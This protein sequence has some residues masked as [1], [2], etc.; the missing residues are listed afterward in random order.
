[1][2]SRSSEGMADSDDY[3][4]SLEDVIDYENITDTCMME[5]NSPDESDNGEDYENITDTCMMEMNNPDE[6]DNGED[7]NQDTDDSE[8]E[9]ESGDE[10]AE[11]IEPSGKSYKDLVVGKKKSDSQGENNTISVS[12]GEMVLLNLE[13][14]KKEWP[15]V[16]QIIDF[17]EETCMIHWYRGSKTKP[18][19]PCSRM[20]QGKKG[21][22][23]AWTQKI[24]KTE[25]MRNS[26]CLTKGGFLPKN[27]KEFCKSHEL[28]AKI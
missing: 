3:F 4:N 20:I 28:Q 22:R 10:V 15:Q 12:I 1:M 9:C 6:S 26:F 27:V 18:W 13:E 8:L 2:A 11:N 7:S 21:K 25:I 19:K 16:A 5:M 23:E 14:Y 24:S 17:D